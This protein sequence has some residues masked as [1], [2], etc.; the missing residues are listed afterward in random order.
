[1]YRYVDLLNY[2]EFYIISV[3][4]KEKYYLLRS[5]NGV[6]IA[7]IPAVE[8]ENPEDIFEVPWDYFEIWN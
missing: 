5:L 2:G 7:V 8:I 6:E 1:M 4:E 3:E